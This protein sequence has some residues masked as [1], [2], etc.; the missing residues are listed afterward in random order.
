MAERNKAERD[1][2]IRMAGLKAA[3]GR[4]REVYGQLR[5]HGGPRPAVYYPPG[6][7][8]ANIIKCHSLDPE[9]LR[10]AFAVGGLVH[11]GPRS[12]PW[13][14]REMLNTVVSAANNCF[15]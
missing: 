3:S 11:W 8:V 1:G 13:L 2:W 10:L 7:D 12:L 15:Y 6:G 9:A 5:W 14:L 4:L